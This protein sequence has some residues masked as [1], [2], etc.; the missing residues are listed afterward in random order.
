M[1]STDKLPDFS[2]F[3]LED[4]NLNRGSPDITPAPHRLR[5]ARR[6]FLLYLEPAPDSCLHTSFVTF[7]EKTLVRYGPNQAHNTPPHISILPRILIQ[8]QETADVKRKWQTVQDLID[9]IDQQI[10]SL[11]L[12]VPDFAGY[13][14]LDKPTRSLIMNVK[15]HN[16]YYTLVESVELAIGPA[17]AVLETHLLDKIHL[18]YNVLKSLSKADL[19]KMKQVAE[20][21]IDIYDWVKSGGSWRLTLYEVMIESQVVGVQH[22]LKEVRSW[23]VQPRPPQQFADLLPVSVRIKLPW[24]NYSAKKQTHSSIDHSSGISS[25]SATS[26]NNKGL[27]TL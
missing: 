26:S 1:T 5:E 6:S 12:T 22:Q 21:T 13:Q 23:P 3:T 10:R 19:K 9:C 2:K 11:Q 15:V 20:S 24:L 25:K 8:R 18:A 17:C 27:H 14:I 7:Q 4:F 16:D